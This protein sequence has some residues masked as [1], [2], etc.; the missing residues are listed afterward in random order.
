MRIETLAV[1]A[2]HVVDPATGA[3][4]P[5]IQLSTTFQREADGS[6][7]S[8]FVYGR[9]ANPNRR[10]LETA[11]AA[12][13]GGADAAAFGSGLAAAGAVFQALQ[14]GDHVIV[15][16]QAY[17]GTNKMLRDVFIPWGLQVAFVDMTNLDAVRAAVRPETK[18]IGTETPSNPLLQITDL[19][20]IADIAHEARALCLCDNT[21]APIVQRPF[22]TGA[23]LIVHSTTKYIGG[24]SDVTGGTVIAREN[25]PL[26]EK[27]R[28]LQGTAG[29]VPSPFDCWLLLR[30]L[31]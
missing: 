18:I 30:G 16:A 5:P 8:G 4:A 23:D 2:G 14:P 21:W 22:E 28:M 7:A 15:P 31:Q 13:E 9:S 29:A 12:L 19:R 6:Y 11:L 20:A 10:A 3:V 24:H 17:H 25:S 1:H 26:W 27:L